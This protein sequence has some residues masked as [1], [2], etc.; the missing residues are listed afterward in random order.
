MINHL[1]E[2][3]N[4]N[5]LPMSTE[6][7]L[8]YAI[9]LNLSYYQYIETWVKGFLVLSFIMLLG[10]Y[11]HAISCSWCTHRMIIRWTRVTLCAGTMYLFTY[12]TDLEA[13]GKRETQ[14]SAYLRYKIKHL[15][16]LMEN[17]CVYLPSQKTR[18]EYSICR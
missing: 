8:T 12:Y 17:Q 10:T 1:I 5:S 6:V 9:L 11:L 3:I 13:H 4:P 14:L 18:M 7:D 16:N 15:T 2:S